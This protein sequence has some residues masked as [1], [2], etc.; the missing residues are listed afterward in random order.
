MPLAGIDR[1]VIN[2]NRRAEAQTA[3]VAANEHDVG[4]A[5]GRANAGHH[6]NVV[7]SRA[8]GTVNRQEH[9]AG[10]PARID[11][12]AKNG[13]PAH[14]DCG[15]LVK[16]GRDIWVLRIGR[17]NA[18]ETASLV[19]ATNEEV[20]VGRDIECSP[21]RAVGNVNWTLPGGPA[22]GGTAEFS[23]IASEEAGPKLV[24]EAVT[25]AGRGFIDRKPFLVAAVRS[26][27][28]RPLCPR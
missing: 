1:I 18:P 24:L 13:A 28:G 19:S 9:L 8:T 15:H 20:T 17:A 14:V 3:V 27:V 23:G 26:A 16:C 22:I 7:V 5:A 21:D 10:K 2:P 11:S 6:V 25:H 4:P 12:A